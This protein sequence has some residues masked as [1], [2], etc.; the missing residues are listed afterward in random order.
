MAALTVAGYYNALSICLNV[1]LLITVLR[2]TFRE[3]E[4]VPLVH[5]ECKSSLSSTAESLYVMYGVGNYSEDS[6]QL[7]NYI[8]SVTSRQGPGGRNISRKSSPVHFSQVC[9]LL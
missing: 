3:Q 2:Q 5:H 8:R 7:L 4:H 1:V 9:Q 6:P